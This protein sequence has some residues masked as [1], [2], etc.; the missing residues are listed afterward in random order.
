MVHQFQPLK[1]EPAYLKVYQAIEA[2]I[3]SGAL[4]EGAVLP[5]EAMLCE[6][7]AVTRATVR[8]GLRLL[9]QADLVRRGAA[10]RFVVRRPDAGD[11]ALAASKGLALGGATFQEVWETLSAMYPQ[12]A[13]I[14]AQ[15]LEKLQINELRAINAD[16]RAAATDDAEAT[17]TFAVAFFQCL[18]AGLNNRVLLALLQSLNMMIEAS[19]QQV[20]LKTPEAHARILEAQGHIIAAL[21]DRNEERAALWMTRHIDDLKRGYELAALNFHDRVL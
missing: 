7:F 1:K 12:A 4:A 14:A 6:Q 17:V 11:V 16:L 3:V 19:L 2:E 18:A 5:T 9:E 13:R 20:I 21:D 15:R 10:K 8:E